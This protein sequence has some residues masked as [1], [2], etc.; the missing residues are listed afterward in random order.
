MMRSIFP[1]LDPRDQDRQQLVVK[2]ERTDG[3][4]QVRALFA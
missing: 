2:G 1:Y 4:L 3:S